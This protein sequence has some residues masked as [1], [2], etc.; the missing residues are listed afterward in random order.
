MPLLRSARHFD[1]QFRH[2]RPLLIC[3]LAFVTRFRPIVIGSLS[4]SRGKAKVVAFICYFHAID[5][6]CRLTAVGLEDVAV[7]V[8]TRRLLP[9]G[10]TCAS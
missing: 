4:S 7:N 5:W 6:P 9:L 2:S 10:L 1:F 3:S 8:W